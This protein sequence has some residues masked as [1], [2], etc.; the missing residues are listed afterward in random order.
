MRNLRFL[1]LPALCLI[2][3]TGSSNAQQSAERTLNTLGSLTAVS[4]YNSYFSI[5]LMMD[6][7][8]GGI[9]DAELATGMLNEQVLWMTQMG[10]EIDGLLQSGELIG[11]GDAEFVAVARSIFS[12]L[13]VLAGVAAAHTA[14]SSEATLMRFEEKRA[15]VWDRISVFLG[16]E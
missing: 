4:I 3:S 12:D 9:H 7:Y 13:E 14:N 1:I 15:E 6:A 5:G 2:L 10:V 16:F 8:S 11:P